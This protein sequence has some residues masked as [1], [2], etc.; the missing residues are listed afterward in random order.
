MKTKVT[1]KRGE[2]AH[3]DH[4]ATLMVEVQSLLGP[5]NP[6]V[7]E[8][9]LT[10]ALEKTRHAFGET[11]EVLAITD[12]QVAAPDKHTLVA[13]VDGEIVSA[14]SSEHSALTLA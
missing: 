12:I 8:L 13:R 3:T 11:G 7:F 4:L 10:E 2:E 9:E 6:R 14:N 1:L 5:P